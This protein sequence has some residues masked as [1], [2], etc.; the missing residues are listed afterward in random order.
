MGDITEEI[1]EAFALFDPEETGSVPIKD[2]PT[3]MR[4]MGINPTEADMLDII[5]DV[6]PENTGLIS[7][8]DFQVLMFKK[9]YS[10]EAEEDLKDS[11]RA[12]DKEGKGF[13]APSDLRSVLINLGEKLTD[14][15]IEEMIREVGTNNEGNIDYNHFLSLMMPK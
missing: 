15:E 14:E 9:L 8:Q 11:L 1:Q 7:Y 6:D 13:V 2:L 10:T 5:T 12:V 3:A 4:A